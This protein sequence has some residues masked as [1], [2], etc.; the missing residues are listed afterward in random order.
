MAPDRQPGLAAGDGA[1][2]RH[3][4]GDELARARLARRLSKEQIADLWPPYP[5]N[6]PITLAELARALPWDQL[7][8][9]LPP[10]PPGGIG[11]NAWV[12]GPA[13]STTGGALLAND[14]HLHLQAPG[15]W[16]LAHLATP[17]LELVRATLPGLPAVVLGHN[18]AIAWGFTNTG[19]D[20][21]DL[22]IERVDPE[23]PT[24]YLTPGGAAP[25]AV[26]EEIIEVAGG[27]RVALSVRTARHGPVISDLLP[28][29]AA[30]FGAD[31]VVALAW[32]AP[33]EDD[34]GHPGA[35]RHRSGTGLERV[36]RG[37]ARGGRADQNIFY[38][39]ASGHIGFIAR[40][41]GC[42]SA[43][44]ATAAGRCPN[45][46]ENTTGRDGSRSMP[47]RG[48]SI[49][50]ASMLFNANNRI[51]PPELSAYLLTADWEAPY[52]ARQI[53]EL[54]QHAPF[55]PA[56]FATMQADVLSLLA[57]D[58]RDHAHGG[59]GVRQRPPPWPGSRRGTG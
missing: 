43:S 19:A 2:S 25:F 36:R 21:Q 6:A 44:G 14:P 47:C 35:A 32:S 15:V 11:S 5:D 59:A 33:G 31:L 9:V 8:A 37:A 48:R 40:R 42:R 34:P 49:L 22:F 23:N 18:S 12:V 16:Y 55:G 57:Q 26:R 58:L 45:G 7:A 30:T 13:R 53:A 27:A 29:A 10:A 38:A 56:E 20:T 3:Q 4:Y 24:R 1:R 39:D 46:A 50:R 28:D 52:R 54:L 17:G 41:A 51:V